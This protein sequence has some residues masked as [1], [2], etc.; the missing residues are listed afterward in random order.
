MIPKVNNT[1]MKNEIVLY[2]SNEL[3]ERIEVRI[4]DET[5]WLTQQQMA[6]LFMQTKQNISLHINNCFKENEL[7][8]IS[9]V[10][11]YLTTATFSQLNKNS[12]ENI[13]K[14]ITNFQLS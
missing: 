7:Q 5:V 2:Q 1:E 4:E 11:D 6:A 9:V 8:L 12:V 13:L 10:K 14:S 3:P